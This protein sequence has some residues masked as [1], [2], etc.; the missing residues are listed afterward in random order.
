MSKARVGLPPCP[1]CVTEARREN[2]HVD[3]S[4]IAPASNCAR[5][6]PHPGEV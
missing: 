2:R 1:R 6:E 5:H 3:V 4:G